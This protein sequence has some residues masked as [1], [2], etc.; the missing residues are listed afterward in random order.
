MPMEWMYV[1]LG[2]CTLVHI[3]GTC[4]YVRVLVLDLSTSAVI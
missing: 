3:S 2:T 1:V 4:T